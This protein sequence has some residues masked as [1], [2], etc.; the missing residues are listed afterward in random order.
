MKKTINWVAVSD[1]MPEVNASVILCKV[2][3]GDTTYIITTDVEVTL[4]DEDYSKT[5]FYNDNLEKLTFTPTHWAYV[6][7]LP[8]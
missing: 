7:F 6:D 3:E 5:V 2:E 4:D 8:I 1:G